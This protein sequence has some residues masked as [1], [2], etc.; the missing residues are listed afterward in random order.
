M[1]DIERL[2]IYGTREGE[3]K[4]RIFY[5]DGT[6]REISTDEAIEI[7]HR[8]AVKNN[9]SKETFKKYLQSD[10]CRFTL[11][12][13][14]D[15]KDEEAYLNSFRKE[16]DNVLEAEN[17]NGYDVNV[18]RAAFPMNGNA[19]LTEAD[20]E[21][22]FDSD[23]EDDI[24]KDFDEFDEEEV[25][26]KKPGKIKTFFINMRDK[27]RE[28][29]LGVKLTALA[30]A[31][32]VIFG[33]YSCA[34][35]RSMDGRI[36]NN[37]IEYSQTETTKDEKPSENETTKEET[38]VAETAYQKLLA[39]ATSLKQRE[40]M[41]MMSDNLDYYNITFANAHK[42]A[43]KD[44]KATMTWDE[45]MALQIAVNDYSDEELRELF[46]QLKV[47]SNF[48]GNTMRNYNKANRQL[49]FSYIIETK[50]ARV[51]AYKLVEST[52]GK[53]FVKKYEDMYFAAHEATGSEKLELVKKFYDSVRKDFNLNTETSYKQYPSYYQLVSNIVSAG[54]MEFQN[55]EVD[56]TL[57]DAEIARFQNIE[58]CEIAH[59]KFENHLYKIVESTQTY[60]Y[61]SK[62]GSSKD[63]NDSTIY[64]QFKEE[65]VRELTEKGYYFETE[66]KRDITQYDAFKKRV[67][68]EVEC[69]NHYEESKIV[70]KEEKCEENVSV[71]NEVEKSSRTETK[72][73]YETKKKVTNTNDRNEAIRKSSKEQVEQAEAEVNRKIEEENEARKEEAERQAEEKRKQLKK[74]LMNKLRKM[75]KK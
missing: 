15:A 9:M 2:V 62:D 57:N 68:V 43:G 66:E 48:V 58:L 35:K 51:N 12:K 17:V 44:I 22:D 39:Q 37:N 42:E 60:C 30:I 33:I 63:G 13:T 36:A 29:H 67:N 21:D 31:G 55:L 71:R 49:M 73:T 11:G 23:Y 72:T 61:G 41:Q 54:E 34:Q 70:E 5:A 59:D 7:M 1:K 56:Y 69:F 14:I 24:E 40:V 3:R 52:E 47:N 64:G 50:E 8:T 10:K 26:K 32:A 74:K 18:N 53:E 45:M 27:F 38:K 20:F 25:S 28:S 19:K 46:P 16:T 6:E 75:K 4:A 65:K